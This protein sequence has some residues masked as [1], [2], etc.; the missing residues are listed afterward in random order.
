MNL[1]VCNA[2]CT[3]TNAQLQN[4][5]ND[6][7]P[8][9]MILTQE[10]FTYIGS[11]KYPKAKSC[12][13]Q[14]STCYITLR[15]G[16]SATGTILPTSNFPAANIRMT[17][18]L[19][20]T[21]NLSK[22]QTSTNN[23]APLSTIEPSGCGAPPCVAAW[24]KVQWI[25]VFPNAWGGGPLL[26]FGAIDSAGSM[27]GS[28]AQDLMSEE[29]HHFLVDQVYLRGDPVK[30]GW[31]GI[32]I[33]ARDVTV[34]NSYIKD[35]KSMS[36]TQGIWTDNLT[37][38]L[39]IT[40][41][42]IEGN[43]ENILHGG[44]VPTMV[45]DTTVLGSPA[46]TVTTATLAAAVKDWAF[47]GQGISFTVGGVLK[48][49]NITS[50][51]GANVGFTAL[52]SAPD[53]SGAVNYSVVPRNATITKNYLVKPL[54]WRDNIITIPTSVVATGST[55]GGSCAAGTYYYKV[56]ARHGVSNGNT[57]TSAASAEDDGVVA[58]GSTGSISVTWGTVTNAEV[59]YVY[60]GT[61][62]G[63]ENI[64]FSV[65]APTTAFTD[66]CAAGTSE[67]PTSTGSTWTIKNLYEVKHWHTALV[68][69]NYMER[70]WLSGQAGYQIVF[71][72]L[73]NSV[74]T[75]GNNSAVV[76]DITFRNN[77][78]K[79]GAGA[80][81][82]VGR[83]ADNDIG[84]R[85]TNMSITNNVFEDINT[86]WGSAVNT[87][88]VCCGNVTNAYPNTSTSQGTLNSL[89]SHN[90]FINTE[91]TSALIFSTHD[92]TTQYEQE[93]FIFRDN[94]I[95]Q[96]TY[97]LRANSPGL[98]AEGQVSWAAGTDATSVHTKNVW[99][100]TANCSNY[101]GAPAAKYCP[102]VAVLQ[103][104][105][106]NYGTADYR[107]KA[108]SQFKNDGSD[109][110]DIGANIPT[111]TAFTTI[112]LSGNNSG[113]GGGG[114]TPPT[115]TTTTMTNGMFGRV[116]S[117]QLTVTCPSAPCTWSLESGTIPTG[118]ALSS[119]GL[120]SGTPTAPGVFTYTVKATGADSLI[121][122]QILE[123]TIFSTRPQI[124]NGME[125]GGFVRA[126]APTCVDQVRRGDLWYDEFSGILKKAT[127]GCPNIFWEPA[128]N[129][130][131][132]ASA[133]TTGLMDTARLGTG[134]ADSTV[135]LRGDRTWAAPGG[136]GGTSGAPAVQAHSIYLGPYFE[137][138]NLSGDTEVYNSGR[139]RLRIDTE[140][141]TTMAIFAHFA[142][143]CA[144]GGLLKI[145]HWTGSTWADSGPSV[146]CVTPGLNEGTFQ[147]L[148]AGAKA[149]NIVFRGQ[150]TG[151]D[152]V[153]DPGFAMIR[154]QLR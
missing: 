143:G 150:I 139:A 48:E 17:P 120:V 110:T 127:A 90:T 62:P 76:R 4:A 5:M 47:V 70:S 97:G 69:G 41:N 103:A 148:G 44:S 79:S 75:N 117:R 153:A 3:Y 58:S 54:T 66:T 136:G 152:G 28:D 20:A 15:T 7:N 86:T 16:V 84:D 30:G 114:G 125:F 49:T 122:T 14:N 145:Q 38:N 115:I 21:G 37:G 73:N 138:T 108:T 67:T 10:G 96:V 98:I 34:Q 77:W 123:H 2:G 94:I 35:I 80:I 146:S 100:G 81:Q 11:F 33:H 101:P 39:T 104:E 88:L 131:T 23:Y 26:Q 121:D 13:A 140:N 29:P 102:S 128:G 130:T 129:P 92:G 91:G 25:E 68:E 32:S 22:F 63:A 89:I 87:I 105:F 126:V 93:G 133:L 57:A 118:L 99:A 124:V 59:Y 116:Y 83:P 31:R 113:G 71:T 42:H 132:D 27:P 72:V 135:F 82:L 154:V 65:N 141:S 18:A 111:I 52:P 50:I 53:V 95:H 107:L 78:V 106:E 8:G 45:H 12:P 85:T 147:A 19:A 56:T 36:D 51:S 46:P 144:T 55:T 137:H 60:R 43:G 149:Q 151:G 142:S 119:G 112:A 61:S 74:G 1:T 134:T 24:W 6:A 109:G 40:N 9:D 64:R